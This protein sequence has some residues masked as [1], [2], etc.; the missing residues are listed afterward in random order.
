MRTAI[1]LG[2][3]GT[4]WADVEQAL[5][6]GRYAEVWACNDVAAVWPG[7][8]DGAVSLHPDKLPGWLAQRAKAG[9]PAPRK[10]FGQ[11]TTT[12]VR[13]PKGV[14]LIEDKFPG[15]TRCGSSG[16]FALKAALDHC[17]RAVLCGVPMEPRGA[18]FF[19]PAEWWAAHHYRTAWEEALP[20]I[21]DRARSLSGWTRELLGAPTASFVAGRSE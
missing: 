18:H 9:L 8:L 11:L 19:H 16:L 20:E 5:S 10:V 7:R 6:L 21:K 2:G 15:Q 14:E 17:D 12:L 4:V 3:G 13:I 1:V